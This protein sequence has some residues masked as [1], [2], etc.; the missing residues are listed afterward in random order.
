MIEERAQKRDFFYYAKLVATILLVVGLGVFAINQALH[1]YYSTAFLS[2][3][4]D[5]CKNLN[6]NM[7]TCIDG[8]FTWRKNLHLTINGD[9]ADDLGNCYTLQGIKINCTT[10]TEEIKINWSTALSTMLRPYP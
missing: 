2:N 6:P 8:C 5:L 9:W 4:C 7:S 1:Y 3:P 10:N